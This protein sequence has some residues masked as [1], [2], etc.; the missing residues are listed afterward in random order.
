[1]CVYIVF[2]YRAIFSDFIS[3]SNVQSGQSERRV[4]ADCAESG[5]FDAV[6]TEGS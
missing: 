1:M 5:S 4:R 6:T 3:R 2:E